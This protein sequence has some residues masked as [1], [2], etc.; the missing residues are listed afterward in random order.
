[1]KEK[2]FRTLSNSWSAEVASEAVIHLQSQPY[3]HLAYVSGAATTREEHPVFIL[4]FS[5]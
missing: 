5:F 4:L 2:T 3:D 1:M